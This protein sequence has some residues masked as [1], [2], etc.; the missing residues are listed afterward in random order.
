M[1]AHTSVT[2]EILGILEKRYG[3][4]LDQFLLPPPSF[5]S[6]HGEFLGFDLEQGVLRTRFPVLQEWLNPYGLM[7]G[8]LIAA[9]VDNTLGPLSMLVA[10]PNVTRRLEL[11]F[12]QGVVAS[13]PAILVEARLIEQEGRWLRFQAR[14]HDSNGARFASATATHWI[15]EAGSA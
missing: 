13:I 10:P 2:N 15:L 4:Q 6:M 14:V 11:K 7:Q 9:A 5:E 8:G 3:G 12:S 1:M